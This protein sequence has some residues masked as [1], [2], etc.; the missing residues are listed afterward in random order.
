MSLIKTKDCTVKYCMCDSFFKCIYLGKCHL[1]GKFTTYGRNALWLIKVH[2]NNTKKLVQ[3][4]HFSK[5]TTEL[6]PGSRFSSV[7]HALGSSGLLTPALL[8]FLEDF[9]L[10]RSSGHWECRASLL[11]CSRRSGWCCM[12]AFLVTSY[13]PTLKMYSKCIIK[14]IQQKILEIVENNPI[15][16]AC[17]VPFR[18]DG[19]FLCYRVL[20]GVIKGPRGCFPVGPLSVNICLEWVF[21]LRVVKHWAGWLSGAHHAVSPPLILFRFWLDETVLLFWSFQQLFISLI[22]KLFLLLPSTLFI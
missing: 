7:P 12:H 13:C 18:W 2:N 14:K 4:T 3:L 21:F 6:V 9:W 16:P 8:L 20:A 22:W 19:A 17:G 5:Q 15:F 11:G 1:E 10:P